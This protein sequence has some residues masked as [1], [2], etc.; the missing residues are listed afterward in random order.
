MSFEDFS[1]PILASQVVP[2]A[3]VNVQNR[4]LH[5]LLFA[6]V[7]VRA[8]YMSAEDCCIHSPFQSAYFEFL[9]DLDLSEP[10]FS[11]ISTPLCGG[12]LSYFGLFSIHQ[13]RIAFR[14][15]AKLSCR[16]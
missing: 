2:P 7:H 15:S 1:L 13:I 5:M 4:L 10:H 3:Y 6:F 12:V 11:R 8:E 16:E 14:F 9:E